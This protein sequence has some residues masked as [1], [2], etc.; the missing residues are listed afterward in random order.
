M[1]F[2]KKNWLKIVAVIVVGFLVFNIIKAKTAKPDSQTTLTPKDVVVTPKIADISEKLT[3]AGSISANDVATLHFPTAGKMVWVGVKVGDRV[4]KWQAI[5]SLDKQQLKKNLQAQFNNYRT[6]L[7]QFQDTQDQY[8]QTRDKYLVTDTIKRILER[9]NYSL[10]NSVINYEI[11]DM[12]IADSTLTTPIAGVVISID[13]PLA[14]VNV[15]PTDTFVIINPES[16]YFQSDIDQE[17]VSQ[18]K[19]GDSATITLDS[20]PS[21]V[22]ESKIT[23]I[24][25]VPVAGQSS[26]VYQARFNLPIIS[27]QD[28]SYRLGMSGDVTTTLKQA[29]NALTIP[30]D[31]L[32]TDDTSASSYVLIKDTLTELS[33][34]PVK[35]GIENDTDVQILEGLS[36]N[37]SIVIKKK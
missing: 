32:Y 19:I 1:D 6:S 21:Q 26:T 23:Y 2:L 15:S 25:F 13:K 29:A 17:E 9:T 34:R 7:S 18:V 14:G 37:E 4:K 30:L 10:D 24:S 8:Q 12:A 5:A 22:L 33:R 20:F 35:T 11:A 16:I 28:L 27:N 31:A 36:P 3:L